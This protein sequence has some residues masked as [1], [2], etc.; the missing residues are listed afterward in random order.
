MIS[1]RRPRSLHLGIG[2]Y[3][4]GY[5][6]GVNTVI[7]RNVKALLKLG[8]NLKVTLFGKLSPDYQNFINPV[9][10]KIEYRN[11]EEFDPHTAVRQLGKSVSEQQVHDYMWQG[12]NIAE[13]LLRKL[14]DMDVII[15]EN[16][17]VG[18][19]P[20][21]TYAFYLYTQY[22]WSVK[23]SKKFIYRFHDFV[24]Q[25]PANFQNV[26]K[27][28]HTRFNI[29][30]NWHSILYPAYPNIKYIAINQ[31]DKWRLIEHGIEEENIYYIP[32]P[33]DKS[34]IPPDDRTQE[35]RSK[36][37]E[38][39][40]LDPSIRFILYPVRCIRRKNVE[41]A[42]F[43][44]CFFNALAEGKSSRKDC[45]LKG[46]FHLLVSIKPDEGDEARYAEKLTG[47]AREHNLPVTIGLDDLVSLERE[48]DPEDPMKIIKY[49]IGDL[50]RLAD[51]V[52]TTSVLEGFGF[53]YIEP[54]I[55]DRAVIGRN[56][57]F[58]TPDFQAA[59][60]KLGH[61]YTALIV[62]GKDFKD[63]GQNSPSPDEV[64]QERLL[65]VLKLKNP[66][67]VDKF[68]ESNETTVL[69]TLKLFDR[70]KREKLIFRNKKIVETVYSAESIARKLYEVVI[71]D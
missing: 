50:Y 52:I 65:K 61:L 2:H 30:P 3:G 41:E 39:E 1:K 19:H 48:Y 53:M 7:S 10:G 70:E 58:I 35:L 24:Q 21:L 17:G 31:N 60:M 13:I 57:P 5:K 37:I 55:L 59:G 20:A 68:I 38:R 25:R 66:K 51:L 47:F 69:A 40:K 29:V 67:F 36:I 43:L 44:T 64:L 32:N 34:I 56:I 22:S 42:I 71:S 14:A 49:G 8:K 9:P 28:Q 45:R 63:I 4:I 62:E 11:V 12:T 46:R 54:W 16:L 26:K 6:D 27:F 15:A 23:D 33:V 18:I